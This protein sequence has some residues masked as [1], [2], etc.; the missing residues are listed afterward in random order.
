ME[1]RRLNLRLFNPEMHLRLFRSKRLLSLLGNVRSGVERNGTEMR[2]ALGFLL[3][4]LAVDFGGV[5]M[6]LIDLRGVQR[7]VS[8]ALADHY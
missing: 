5:G 7:G 1:P 2:G 4:E 3:L 6:D 8:T